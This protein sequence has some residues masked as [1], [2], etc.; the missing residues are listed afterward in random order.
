MCAP[1]PRIHPLA[2][3]VRGAKRGRGFVAALA[4]GYAWLEDTPND[5]PRKIGLLRLH[6]AGGML[7]LF[8]MLVRFAVRLLSARPAPATTGFP[9]LDRLVPVSHYGFY[10]LV[11]LMAGTG[12]ATALLAGLPA[13]VFGGSGDPLPPSFD[14]YPTRVAHGL[15]ASVLGLLIILHVLAAL[16]H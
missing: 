9:P 4:Q 5:D 1:D 14:A 13:I 16:Y 10:V 11:V 12:F 6:M 3:A 7:I 15:I 2:T 8:L